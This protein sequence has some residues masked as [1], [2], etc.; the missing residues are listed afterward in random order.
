VTRR[1]DKN[2]WKARFFAATAELS[3]IV[4]TA[5]ENEVW[6]SRVV[7]MGLA[8]LRQRTLAELFAFITSQF[9]GQYRERSTIV[10][11]IIDED[12]E[13]SNLL[14]V[15][16]SSA[17]NFPGVLVKSL[18]QWA[19]ILPMTS[20]KNEAHESATKLLARSFNRADF[21]AIIQPYS[22]QNH[23]S[24][25]SETGL[26]S[27]AI[28]PLVASTTVIGLLAIGSADKGR[29][30]PSHATDFLELLAALSASAIESQINASRL[31]L[32][33]FVDPLTGLFNRRYLDARLSE[34][35]E[36]AR[37]DRDSLT[38]LI[39]DADHFKKVNDNVGHQGGDCVLQAIA[40][41]VRKSI[42]SRD[43]SARFGGE[44]FVVVAKHLTQAMAIQLAERI[45]V[46]VACEDVVAG[47][48]GVRLSV[49]VS[50][51][52][53]WASGKTLVGSTS[54]I[55]TLLNK[56]ADSALYSAK[57]AGRNRVESVCI[58]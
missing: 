8:V 20:Q 28:V 13:I 1:K 48:D 21:H 50:I 37:E 22:A 44:E 9:G 27:V 16:G 2:I 53:C 29:L 51:G 18:E 42:K 10:V 30:S 32:T 3:Q 41:R 49:S 12:G 52:C 24:L 45:R 15:Q 35:I 38:Y 31:Q 57:A 40:Q 14:K 23:S 54:A 55:A 58:G 5:T 19:N 43:I 4:G 36:S 26:S 25:F 7:A 56:K 34:E 47:A 39:I 17:E 33:G 46:A 11:R 6:L